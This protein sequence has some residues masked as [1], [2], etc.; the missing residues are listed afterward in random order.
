MLKIIPVVFI[1]LFMGIRLLAQEPDSEPKLKVCVEIPLNISM[2]PASLQTFNYGTTSV[3]LPKYNNY[4]NPLFGINIGAL[5]SITKNFQAGAI[6]GV[7]GSF[8]QNH[9]YNSG[10]YLNM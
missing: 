5:Y 10:E 2:I 8:Y 3:N 6:I 9:L 4:H 1:F 7:N